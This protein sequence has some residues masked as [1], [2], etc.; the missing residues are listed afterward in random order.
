[1]RKRFPVGFNI[2]N[3]LYQIKPD[4]CDQLEERVE[5]WHKPHMICLPI[6]AEIEEYFGM[7]QLYLWDQ[8]K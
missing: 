5:N 3:G 8:Y 1:M 4:L 7:H 6:G 2:L